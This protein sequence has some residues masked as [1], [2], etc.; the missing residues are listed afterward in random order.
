MSFILSFH[1]APCQIFQFKN[2]CRGWQPWL[3]EWILW[4]TI[5]WYF[6]RW[7]YQQM[8]YEHSNLLQILKMTSRG[9]CYCKIS[10]HYLGLQKI[11]AT[12]YL[13]TLKCPK[14]SASEI[15][16]VRCRRIF[17]LTKNSYP[18]GFFR[19]SHKNTVVICWV[20]LGRIKE[21]FVLSTPFNYNGVVTQW[22]N[23]ILWF[24]SQNGQVEWIRAPVGPHRLIVS[25]REQWLT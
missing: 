10:G 24:L 8:I 4:K 23:P 21:L 22:C 3:L 13:W 15:S 20:K 5:S 1:R 9:L 19:S 18:L 7:A 14:T 17:C 6:K 11:L 12:N 16:C 2:R 25:T